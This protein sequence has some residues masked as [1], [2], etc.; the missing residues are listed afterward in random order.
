MPITN[1]GF[2]K[3]TEDEIFDHLESDLN[4]RLGIESE[5]GSLVEEQLKAESKTLAE[6]QEESLNQVYKAAYLQ[7]ATGEE[8]DKLVDIIGLN[9][10]DAVAATGTATFSRENIPTSD[11]IIPNGTVVQTSGI[12]PVRYSTQQ[13]SKLSLIDDYGNNNL[14]K[15][16]G[17]IRDASIISSP[18]FNDDNAVEM[19]AT[20]GTSIQTSDYQWYGS[21]YEFQFY[22]KADSVVGVQFGYQDAENYLEV[23]LDPA[24]DNIE[25]RMVEDGNQVQ[26]NDE[27]IVFPSEQKLYG[28][29]NWA[30]HNDTFFTLYQSSSQEVEIG[31]V[32][33]AYD[34][35]WSDGRFGLASYSDVNSFL[36]N[37]S[38][39]TA[40]TVNIEAE[41][42]GS[43]GNVPA[44]TVEVITN[45]LTGVR[46]VTNKTSIGN[47]NYEGINGVSFYIGENEE[48][49]EELRKRAYNDTS[50][51]GSATTDAISTAIR[52]IDGVK[53]V[54]INRNRES[55]AVNGLPAHSFEPVVYGGTDKE[56]AN[57]I[58]DTSSI[59]SHDVGGVNGQEQ[60]YDIYSETTKD[61]ERISWSSPYEVNLN[62]TLDLVVSDTF[63]G[64]EEINSIVAN[65][66]GGTDIDGTQTNGLDVGE[67][68]FEAILKNRVVSPERTGVW[69]VGNLSIDSNSDGTDDTTENTSGADVLEV[70][71]NEVALVNARDGSVTVNTTQL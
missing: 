28:V 17:D 13:I 53:S 4:D 6:L 38:G 15:W 59:D 67:D 26:T 43:N 49:D 30:V 31:S 61:T 44:N 19:P 22:P 8:L 60:T 56:I 24:S 45:G 21:K 1:N 10:K 47:T 5:P 9:R 39:T 70:A 35:T 16:E 3:Y 57:A 18:E 40:T 46:E 66:I 64:E 2:E 23:V 34:E 20:S 42:P 37:K 32:S 11:R 27:N 36:V 69:E 25:I 55:S 52:K 65:Y 62:I 58:F 68:V 41:E 12:S 54:V 7:D 29:L 51:G 71:N 63:V 14:D 48:E 33:F 50:L